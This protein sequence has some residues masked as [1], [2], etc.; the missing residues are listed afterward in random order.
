MLQINSTVSYITRL[1]P[2]K[3]DHGYRIYLHITLFIFL[4][5]IHAP[6]FLC[7]LM[8][9]FL[10]I[11]TVK[12]SLHF[13]L[14]RINWLIMKEITLA[15]WISFWLQCLKLYI[16]PVR[17]LFI[18]FGLQILICC[19]NDIFVAE[20]SDQLTMVQVRKRFSQN[21]IA[22]LVLQIETL[23]LQHLQCQKNR[24]INVITSGNEVAKQSLQNASIFHIYVLDHHYAH[25]DWTLRSVLF[26]SHSS[27]PCAVVLSCFIYNV[28]QFWFRK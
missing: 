26:S 18:D 1:K 11:L 22:T 12:N 23:K 7:L 10:H 4:L 15:N 17:I 6:L 28:I 13:F 14:N 5:I 24:P 9:S 20:L 2:Q 21:N 27:A 25:Q 3:D 16:I 19:K 8:Y